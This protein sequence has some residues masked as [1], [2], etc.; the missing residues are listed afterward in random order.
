MTIQPKVKVSVRIPSSYITELRE[1]AQRDGKQYSVNDIVTTAI[2]LYLNHG[3]EHE[4][5]HTT[6][7][8]EIATFLIPIDT[9]NSVTTYVIQHNITL[10]QFIRTAIQHYLALQHRVNGVSP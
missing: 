3:N 2:T 9:Y 4:Y 1:L 5:P 10:S 8:Y 6:D 7:R